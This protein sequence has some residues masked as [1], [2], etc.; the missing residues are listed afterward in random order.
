MKPASSCCHRF[1]ASCGARHHLL[2]PLRDHGC[3]LGVWTVSYFGD[4]IDWRGLRFMLSP[5]G[6]FGCDALTLP[7]PVAP[8]HARAD[9]N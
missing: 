5:S 4:E 8:V 9:Q 6:E 3:A 7:C 1:T 2:D